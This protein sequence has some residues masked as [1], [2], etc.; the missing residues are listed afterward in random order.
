VDELTAAVLL[1]YPR[2]IDP[3]TNERC[4]AEVTMAGLQEQKR[5]LD[6]SPLYRTVITWRNRV[7]RKSQLILRLLK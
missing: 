3:L 4:E 6:A 2:Y 7:S 1:L 5:K